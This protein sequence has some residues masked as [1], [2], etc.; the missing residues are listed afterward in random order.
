[1][2]ERYKYYSILSTKSTYNQFNK[3]AKINQTSVSDVKIE[4][5]RSVSSNISWII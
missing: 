3:L 4:R 2:K 1:M 5:S